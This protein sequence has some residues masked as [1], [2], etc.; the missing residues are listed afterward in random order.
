MINA[1]FRFSKGGDLEAI[2]ALGI[3]YYAPVL[4]ELSERFSAAKFWYGSEWSII[5]AYL[6]WNYT[7]AQKAG[8]DISAFPAIA[9]HSED[10][11]ARPAHQRVLAREAA[12]LK[13]LGTLP[14]APPG[15]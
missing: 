13:Q 8:L 1:P 6:N 12:E 9:R 14:T 2:K 3:Q 10:A 11:R 5:D 4:K 7:T 15:R